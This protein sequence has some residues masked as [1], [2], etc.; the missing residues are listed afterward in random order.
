MRFSLLKNVV[1]EH[2]NSV[3]EDC[4]QLNIT[5][6]RAIHYICKYTNTP[7]S[8]AENRGICIAAYSY[9]FS[10]FNISLSIEASN[11]LA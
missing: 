5:V 11:I 7:A 10:T 1:F 8:I 3:I 4:L 9:V 6:K 2:I